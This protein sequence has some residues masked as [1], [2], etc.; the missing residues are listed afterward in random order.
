[1]KHSSRNLS[2][3]SRHLA[4][5]SRKIIITVLTAY[6]LLLTAGLTGCESLQRKFTR[7]PTQAPKPPTPIITF[8]DYSR[9]MT[10]LDRYRKHS[11][12][13]DYWNDELIEAVQG[14]TP[15]PKRL[16]RAS[17]EALAELHTMKELL[18]DDIAVRLDPLIE[19]RAKI[20]RQ[21]HS[22]SFHTGS[23][24]VIGRILESQTRQIQREFFWRDVQDHLKAQESAP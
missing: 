16:K 8:Q 12:M 6:C 5:G 9:A 20:H 10:P 2:T 19:E 15:N 3:S 11:L 21:L 23:A 13:F 18:A 14:S 22:P 7:K 17:E 1:M 24:N 4:I